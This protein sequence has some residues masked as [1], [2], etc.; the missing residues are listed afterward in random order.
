MGAVPELVLPAGFCSA[1]AR[2]LFHDQTYRP[3]VEAA[4][5]NNDAAVAYLKQLQG[6]YDGLNL[7]SDTEAMHA[8][9]AEAR[10]YQADAATTFS[11]QAALVRGFDELMA[12]PISPCGAV[13]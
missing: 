10:A 2:N 9:A 8:L 13:K 11:T 1:E 7:G 6:M 12:V 5:H 4:K 3:A